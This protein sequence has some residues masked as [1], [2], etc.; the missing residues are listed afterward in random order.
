[1]KPTTLTVWG[2]TKKEQREIR[3]PKVITSRGELQMLRQW[4]LVGQVIGMKRLING[5]NSLHC[6]R[7]YQKSCR[8]ETNN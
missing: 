4:F 2:R 7:S 5:L 8:V 6:S 3:M 1:M